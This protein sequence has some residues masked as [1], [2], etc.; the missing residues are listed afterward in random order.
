V[1]GGQVWESKIVPIVSKLGVKDAGERKGG[2]SGTS[3]VG[4][5]INVR[6]ARREDREGDG[7]PKREGKDN[8]RTYRE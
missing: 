8:P 5:G 1:C 6:E 3:V 4:V 2:R 7:K